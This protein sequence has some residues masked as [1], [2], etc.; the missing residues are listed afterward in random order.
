VERR[1]TIALCALLAGFCTG[2]AGNAL[3]SSSPISALAGSA[4]PTA[5]QHTFSTTKAAEPSVTKKVTDAIAAT[6]FSQSVFGAFKKT[7]NFLT[8]KPKVISAPDPVSLSHKSKPPGAEFYVRMA[9]AT[10]QSGKIDS[11]EHLYHKAIDID[12]KNLDALLGKAHL[13][14]RRNNFA[15]ATELYKKAVVAHPESATA[16][17]DLG[18]CYARLEALAKSLKA[19]ERAIAL[20]P[21]RKL[22]RNNIAKVLTKLN[23]TNDALRHLVAVHPPAVAHNNLGYFLQQDGQQSL[24]AVH[25]A[26]AAQLDPAFGT[27]APILAARSGARPSQKSSPARLD[28]A[29]TNRVKAAPQPDNTPAYLQ[30]YQAQR[31]LENHPAAERPVGWQAS[32]GTPPTRVSTVGGQSSVRVTTAPSPNELGMSYVPAPRPLPPVASAIAPIQ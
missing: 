26:K 15:A 16:H 3:S 12:P 7:T 18:L 14:D 23:R 6:S 20:S 21:K 24:A 32:A 8:P 29:F 5:R 17:N 11:A 22:Y 30:S 27:T 1:Q 10:E 2:C 28:R 25:L 9:Q 31:G 19:L 13:N 4:K